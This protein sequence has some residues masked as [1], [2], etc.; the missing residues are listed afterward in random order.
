LTNT[1]LFYT[2]GLLIKKAAPVKKIRP[3]K[4]I[5]MNTMISEKI[6]LLKIHFKNY[7]QSLFG[8]FTILVTPDIAKSW[9]GMNN[10]NR[11]MSDSHA[12]DLASRMA[13]G[14]WMLNG[15]GILFSNSGVLLDGQHRLSA[16]I[17]FGKP[18]YFDVKFG[19]CDSAFNTLDDGKKRS[20]ADVLSIN[21]VPN[22]TN[23]AAA[24]KKIIYLKRGQTQT[25]GG[26]TGAKVLSNLDIYNWYISH[27][28]MR[29]SFLLGIKWYDISGKILTASEFSAFHYLMSEI[30]EADANEFLS[31]LA[32]GSNLDSSS[33]IFRLRTVLI[34]SKMNKTKRLKN[35]AQNAIIIKSWNYFRAGRKIKQLKFDP[36][37]EDF[38]VLK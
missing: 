22:A 32:L 30:D 36:E 23:T 7:V 10:K 37:R 16:V 25:E 33:P 14:E 29:D 18:I 11:P 5:I 34:Q 1:I 15:Q 26:Q 27:P 8:T 31:R 19:V 13:K 24:I 28:Q 17:K 35:F 20:A 6:D 12:S 3:R 38:P 21:N 2:F 4:S 9:L